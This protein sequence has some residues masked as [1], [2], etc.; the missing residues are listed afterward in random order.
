VKV[1]GKVDPVYA[2][3]AWRGGGEQWYS[4]PYSQPRHGM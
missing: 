1:K 2:V 4:S 3:K